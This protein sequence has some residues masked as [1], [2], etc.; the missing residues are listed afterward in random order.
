VAP[1]VL[2]GVTSL[3]RDYTVERPVDDATYQTFLRVYAYDRTD[4]RPNL[5]SVQ[6]GPYGR[7]EKVS[8]DAAYNN[9]RV[10]AYLFLPNNAD[11]P[12]QAIVYFPSA[13]PFFTPSSRDLELSEINFLVGSGRAVL[14]PVYKGTYERIDAR[15]VFGGPP[16][17]AKRDQ[18]VQMGK[19][20]RRSVDYLQTRSDIDHERL[21]FHGVSEGAIRGPVMTAIEDRFKA[22]ILLA[23]GLFTGPAHL[24]EVDPLNFAPRVRVPTLMINGRDDVLFPL[25]SSQNPLFQ[26]LGV[27][28]KDKRHVLLDGSHNPLRFQE[29]IRETLSWLDKY[30]GPVRLRTG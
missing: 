26:H 28:A 20:L 11:P 19:D 8:F 6:D 10:T 17:V 27:P 25:E 14:F 4:L 15:L 12:F 9:E 1:D 5:E 13:I 7:I 23:G 29:V 21:A 16:S 30:L 24:P 22:S 2:A 3:G 18:K